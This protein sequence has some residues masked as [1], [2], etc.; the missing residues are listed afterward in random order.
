VFSVSGP[1]IG[2]VILL[3]LLGF[4]PLVGSDV[5]LGT[6]EGFLVAPVG[7]GFRQAHDGQARFVVGQHS[8][9]RVDAAVFLYR[10]FDVF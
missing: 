5:S 6:V 8:A 3:L 9:G 7:V 10:G 1:A 2:K 4:V